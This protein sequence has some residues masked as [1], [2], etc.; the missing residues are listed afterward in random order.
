[1]I[2]SQK[3]GFRIQAEINRLAEQYEN[4]LFDGNLTVTAEVEGILKGIVFMLKMDSVSE[5]VPEHWKTIIRNALSD[6]RDTAEEI[7]NY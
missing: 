6:W 2:C 3:T 4:S 1:M 7:I 5:E